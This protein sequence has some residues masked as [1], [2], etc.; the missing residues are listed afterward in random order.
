MF[1][2]G[3]HSFDD[4]RTAAAGQEILRSVKREDTKRET[5][6]AGPSTRRRIDPD[7]NGIDNIDRV[8]DNIH[9][10][11]ADQEPSYQ[12]VAGDHLAWNL[13]RRSKVR[14]RGNGEQ[15]R[16]RRAGLHFPQG[17]QEVKRESYSTSWVQ[18]HLRSAHH[19]Q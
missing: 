3:S 1:G 17:F 2:D 7:P 5:E 19:R 8:G 18:D 12:E 10:T 14:T 13:R 15:G 9:T 6:E 11:S 4:G 16:R